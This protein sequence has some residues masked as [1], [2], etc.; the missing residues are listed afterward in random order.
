[1][2]LGPLLNPSSY[3]IMLWDPAGAYIIFLTTK[4][5]YYYTYKHVTV[6]R[7]LQYEVL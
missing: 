1:V 2:V 4:T 7:L 3:L 6:A 5:N